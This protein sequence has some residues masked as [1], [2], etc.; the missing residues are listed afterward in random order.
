M[1]PAPTRKSE[2]PVQNTN[3]CNTLLPPILSTT[4]LRLGFLCNRY[5]GLS[6][7]VRVIRTSGSTAVLGRPGPLLLLPS[8]LFAMSVRYQGSRVSGV[9]RVPT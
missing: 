7:A 1:V 5:R 2:A 9:M 8:Y 3:F 4:Q 6:R